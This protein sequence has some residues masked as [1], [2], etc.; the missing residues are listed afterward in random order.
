MECD[1]RKKTLVINKDGSFFGKPTII[2]PESEWQYNKN[3]KYGVGD[4]R[5]PPRLLTK[6]STAGK[7]VD[8]NWPNKG[9]RLNLIVNVILIA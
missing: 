5:I 1:G 8:E 3:P 2:L 4:S 6:S 7:S 9:K